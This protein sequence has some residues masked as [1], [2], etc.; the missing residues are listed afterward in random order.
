MNTTAPLPIT[1]RI[2]HCES[3]LALGIETVLRDDAAFDASIVAE[4]EEAFPRVGGGVFIADYDLGLRWAQRD[5]APA[6]MPRAPK[7]RVLVMSGRDR[8]HEIRLA[9]ER[10]VHGYVPA[11]CSPP[12]LLR[13]VLALSRGQ[14]YL[15][16]LV[17]ARMADGFGREALTLREQQVLER[18]ACGE[19]NK[20]I[21]RQLGIAIGTVK[22]H[23]K[24]IMHK[25]G[26]SS[27]TRAICIASDRGLIE[28]HGVES[29]GEPTTA[30]VAH[31][32]A[33][34]EPG[35]PTGS[36]ARQRPLL[37]S[38]RQAFLQREARAVELT[39]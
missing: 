18:L 15:S 1:V 39:T 6:R 31:R 7:V 37:R 32:P 29:A 5:Q 33:Y 26:A 13:A 12:E 34:A 11:A 2:G 22:A 20:S 19:C 21:A 35:R 8:E 17:A 28:V 10:G 36:P 25:L 4:G 27:R 24:A 23:V 3:L 38:D 30:A 9:L 16:P 14:R